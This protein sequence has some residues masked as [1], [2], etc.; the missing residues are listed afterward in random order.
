MSKFVHDDVLDASLNF[1]KTNV[2]RMCACSVQPTTYTQAITTY[3]LADVDIGSS[4]FTGPANGDVS[5]RKLMVNEQAEVDVD[6][7]GDATHVALVNTTD[8]ILRYVTTCKI[9]NMVEGNKTTIPAW[10]IEF[11]DPT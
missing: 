9:K 4:D 7:S 5:G 3:K 2:N 8:E 1:I 11:R 10:N 6:T